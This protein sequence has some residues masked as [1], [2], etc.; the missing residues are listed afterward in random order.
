MIKKVTTIE[1]ARLVE[2]KYG[3]KYPVKVKDESGEESVIWLSGDDE[4]APNIKAN[5][6]LEVTYRDKKSPLVK[7]LGQVERKN[8]DTK[9]MTN[10]VQDLTAIW[11]EIFDKVT[12]H[13]SPATLSDLIPG[14]NTIFIQMTKK[15]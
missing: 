10:D 11:C 15:Y 2:T 7:I 3:K 4:V 14:I 13:A 9:T 5:M 1:S 8:Y 12:A 6:A